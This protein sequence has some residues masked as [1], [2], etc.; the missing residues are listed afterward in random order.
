MSIQFDSVEILDS[1]HI[2]RFMKHETAAER[3]LVDVQLAREDGNVLIF[4]RYGKKIIKLQGTLTAASQTTLDDAIDTFKELF[5]RPEKNLDI[6]W[7]GSLGTMRFVATCQS[8]TFDRDHYNTSAVPWT[9]EF[10][11]SS[12]V[13]KDI[14]TTNAL[15]AQAA[16]TSRPV[17]MSRAT[18]VDP[19]ADS[20]THA[21]TM[22]S[23]VIPG[24]LLLLVFSSDGIP[25]ITA[26]TDW[27]KL[28]QT[29]EATNQTTA[30]IFWKIAQGSDVCTITTSA[31]EQGSAVC[32]RIAGGGTPLGAAA[33]GN[34]TNSD[35]PNLAMPVSDT[36]LWIASRTGDATVVATVAP[37]GYSNL[38]TIAGG[39]A[40]GAST[41]TAEKSSTAASEDP[42]TFTSA[43]EQWVAYTIGIPPRNTAAYDVDQQFTLSGSK[44]AK[45]QI[46]LTVTSFD[47]LTHGIQYQDVDTGER[48]IVTRSAAFVAAKSVVIDCDAKKV[49]DNLSTTGQVEGKFYGV[50]PKFKIG[51][52]NVRIQTGGF[53]NQA[54]SDFASQLPP[55][56]AP[57]VALINALYYAQSFTVPNADDTFAG[58]VFAITKDGTG[59]GNFFWRVV[60][61]NG[62]VPDYAGAT[63][64]SS[65]IANASVPTFPTYQYVYG[66]AGGVFSLAANTRYWIVVGGNSADNTNHYR[67]YVDIP[68]HISYPNGSTQL[69]TNSGTTWV[70]DNNV[71]SFR[72]LFGGDPKA[73][74]FT[75]T[76]AYNKTYL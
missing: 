47:S 13:G 8:H 40:T 74:T 9:A 22:P 33:Q 54:S 59:G 5:S 1:A 57:S 68:A 45:P 25:T 51:A 37:S 36:Y 56:S 2:P 19:G 28:G 12:G 24:D 41:N 34:S 73:G 70:A 29:S 39:S 15:N 49:T 64:A 23:G 16:D 55:S 17:V 66:S 11:V 30:G 63:V 71:L 14:A 50:F 58:F 38:Q 27:T 75:H 61:D 44:A 21:I 26:P 62:G 35:P 10:I 48:M 46:T 18:S 7:G 69:S 42:G 52:N 53:V 3:S 20:T 65:T 67:A 76:V 60:G 4:E 43:T 32:L 31:S 6:T 72:L